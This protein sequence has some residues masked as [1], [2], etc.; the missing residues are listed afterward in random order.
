VPARDGPA[1]LFPPVSLLRS[2]PAYGKDSFISLP[3]ST[4]SGFQPI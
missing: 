3:R 4:L 1:L 2:L